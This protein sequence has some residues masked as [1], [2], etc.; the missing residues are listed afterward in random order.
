ML[1]LAAVSCISK[2]SYNNTLK[3]KSIKLTEEV[4]SLDFKIKSRFKIYLYIKL[5]QRENLVQLEVHRDL[6]HLQDLDYKVQL[7]EFT[8]ARCL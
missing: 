8:F 1:G 3:T 5:L 6:I 7:K 4:F 2:I